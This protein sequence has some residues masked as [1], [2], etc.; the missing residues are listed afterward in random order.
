LLQTEHRH[1]L[2]WHFYDYYGRVRPWDGLI[3]IVR[4]PRIKENGHGRTILRGYIVGGTTF[5]GTWRVWS[6]RPAEIP[7]E[8]AIVLSRQED[9]LVSPP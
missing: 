6:D 5:V 7:W 2:A 8:S 4:E 1:G 3:T 9:N